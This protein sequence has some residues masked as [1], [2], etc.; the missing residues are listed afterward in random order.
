MK[1]KCEIQVYQIQNFFDSFNGLK[2]N[3]TIY[4]GFIY[5]DLISCNTILFESY[6]ISG[7][8]NV[9]LKV[10][11]YRFHFL[12]LLLLFLLIYCDLLDWPE[13]AVSGLFLAWM[14]A[15][16]WKFNLKIDVELDLLPGGAVSIGSYRCQSAGWSLSGELR[17]ALCPRHDWS[18]ARQIERRS[19]YSGAP[20]T[21]PL[22]YVN[23]G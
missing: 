18:L 5:F 21:Y 1:G 14:T 20:T 9:K 12:L 17:H 16:N 8:V 4:L 13:L 6:F 10:W 3:Y 15:L 23:R 2:K 7:E 22:G 11:T 19:P